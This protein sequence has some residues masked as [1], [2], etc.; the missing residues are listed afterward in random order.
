[1]QLFIQTVWDGISTGAIIA[2]VAVGLSLVFRISR[3]IN[4]AHVDFA[5]VAAY[6]T[7]LVAGSTAVAFPVAALVG[8]GAVM[9]LGLLAYLLVYR[10]LAGERSISLIIASIGV[11]FF[12]R[13]L[14]TFIWGSN[15]LAFDLPVLRSIRVAGIRMAPFDIAIIATTLVVFAGLALV[16]RFG[17]FGRSLR[18][19]ADNPELARVS[20]VA[21]DRV[22]KQMWLIGSA[23]AAVGGI[24]LAAKTV[25]TP[26]L[27][28]HLLV[29]AFAAMILGGIGSVGGTLLGALVIGVVGELAAMYWL[30]TYRLAATFGVLVLVLMIRPQGLLGKREVAR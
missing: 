27:G 7:L 18:A 12:L 1:M 16:L 11:A 4:V 15:Q 23:F 24:A 19:V 30:P 8:I 3:F 2:L 13:Y 21:V 22:V 28:W 20:G 29:P 14:V 25:I 26:Y 10:R 17:A 6:V 5:T 9:A